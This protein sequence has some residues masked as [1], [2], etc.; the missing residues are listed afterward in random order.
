MSR[1]GTLVTFRKAPA[2]S[3]QSY[4]QMTAIA[5]IDGTGVRARLPGLVAD[6]K[7]RDRFDVVVDLRSI[8]PR[9]LVG[10]LNVARVPVRPVDVVSVLRDAERIA[11]FLRDDLLAL[12]RRQIVALDCRC[13]QIGPVEMAR[14]VVYRQSIRTA[15]VGHDDLTMRPVEPSSLYGAGIR[16]FRPVKKSEI[17]NHLVH[18]CIKRS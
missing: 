17:Y 2:T 11:N 16:P 13:K 18:T 5:I 4:A 8:G 9:R 15:D 6:Q 3:R 12:L 14:H 1:A 10:S 7:I